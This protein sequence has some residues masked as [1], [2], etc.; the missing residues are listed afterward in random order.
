MYEYR[1]RDFTARLNQNS[2]LSRSEVVRGGG[3]SGWN[4]SRK[5]LFLPLSDF[6]SLC[7]FPF[8]KQ[9]RGSAAQGQRARKKG[10][11]WLSQYTFVSSSQYLQNV[12]IFRCYLQC[13]VTY[14]QGTPFLLYIIKRSLYEIC[15]C[16][17]LKL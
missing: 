10:R 17:I 6:F 5:P 13:V 12:R 4:K 11:V 2:E 3:G 1:N 16:Y 8:E 7:G 9:G 14:L 15:K